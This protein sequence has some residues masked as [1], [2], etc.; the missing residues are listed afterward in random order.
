MVLRPRWHFL[1][2]QYLLQATP[3]TLQ[4][5]AM[6]NSIS[7]RVFHSPSLQ[8]LGGLRIPYCAGKLPWCGPT[9]TGEAFRT[10]F[11]R[12]AEIEINKQ[13]NADVQKAAVTTH[14]SQHVR[15]NSTM[16]TTSS[17]TSFTSVAVSTSTPTLATALSFRPKV[18][19]KNALTAATRACLRFM[20]PSR[21]I[22]AR[23]CGS[24]LRVPVMLR[25]HASFRHAEYASF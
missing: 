24:R 23:A 17:T 7:D 13:K 3:E 19:D 9:N 8:C 11:Q 22:Q 16:P 14:F 21:Q 2:S 6:E 10:F 5:K 25:F 1:S 20:A 12:S 15:S 4:S 18:H